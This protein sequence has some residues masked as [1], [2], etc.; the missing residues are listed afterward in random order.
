MKNFFRYGALS[1][2]FLALVPYEAQGKL[3]TAYISDSPSSSVP[4]WIA[5]EAGLFKKYG[6]DVDL[7]F[8]D[9]STRGIQALLAGDLS[10]TEAV[11]TSA[12]NGKMAGGNIA[13]INGLVN[14][15][16]YYIVGSPAIKSPEDLKGRT[17]AVHI[18]GTA[19]DFALRLALKQ[20]GIPYNQIKAITIG[21]GP[22]RIMA[23]INGQ[24]EFTVASDAE[25]IKGESAGQKVIIDMAE[26]KI[27]F[28]FTC[29]VTTAKM[30]REQPDNVRRMVEAIAAGVHYF[31]T[32]KEDTL[33][34]MSKYTRGQNR[35][36]LE[37][38]YSAYSQLLVADTYPTMEGLRNTLE[39]QASWD[40]KVAKA[41]AEDF[42]ELRFVDQLKNSGF[43]EKLYGRK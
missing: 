26:F 30:I 42:V 41:K 36:L 43:I 16:P 6:L 32:N 15:L 1:Y 40:A 19:A 27:P 12:I 28:Q 38:A 14:T 35:T 21:G 9:G 17:A 13:I 7:V 5:K 25:K 24:V 4:K 31:K 39:V 29:T 11:G 33:R 18:P 34:I 10:F 20:V 3:L 2:L 37:G 22:A 8:I 23:L